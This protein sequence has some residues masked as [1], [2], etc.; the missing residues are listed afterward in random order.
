[1]ILLCRVRNRTKYVKVRQ[2][3]PPP[4]PLF[5][6]MVSALVFYALVIGAGLSIWNWVSP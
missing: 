4:C 2:I 6:G 1:M 5:V 3:P